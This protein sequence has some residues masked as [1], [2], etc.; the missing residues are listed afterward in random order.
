[1][2]GGG[3]GGGFFCSPRAGPVDGCAGG[4]DRGAFGT[5]AGCCVYL[6][7]KLLHAASGDTGP[8]P[9]RGRRL[10]ALCAHRS[11]IPVPFC[12]AL[13]GTSVGA[14]YVGQDMGRQFMKFSVMAWFITACC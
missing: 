14:T 2:H 4:R 7:R 5:L 13:V 10:C 3:G 8:A 6:V 11:T 12:S 1:M 9:K